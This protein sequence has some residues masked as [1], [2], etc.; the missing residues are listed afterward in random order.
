LAIT[1]ELWEV[2]GWREG[3]MEGRRDG[4]VEGKMPIRF[5]QIDSS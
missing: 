2:E 1:R 3:G 5:G 4:G